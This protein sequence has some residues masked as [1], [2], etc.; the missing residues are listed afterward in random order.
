[1]G[2]QNEEVK[3]AECVICDQ[4]GKLVSCDNCPSSYHATCLGYGKQTPRGRWKC[5][6]CKVTKHG[7]P[8]MVSKMAPNERP[9]CDVLADAR[10]LSW[11]VKGA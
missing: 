2:T 9:C 6:F 8:N 3:E 7:I 4:P 11:E 5:Y 10:C 1:M